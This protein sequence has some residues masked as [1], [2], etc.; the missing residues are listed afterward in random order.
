VTAAH[1][2]ALRVVGSF[3]PG[4]D[5]LA[6]K[7]KELVTEFLR[8]AESA[9]ARD[10]F[11]PG[12]VTCTGLVRHPR[13]AK[14]LFMLHHRLHRWLLPG[15]HVEESDKSLADAAGREAREETQVVIDGACAPFLAGID[16]HG[17][18]PKHDE[19]F[20]LHHDLIWCFHAATEEIAVTTEAP[21][22]MWAG[23][24]DWDRL[25]AAESIRRSI[26]RAGE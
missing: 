20:H 3:D 1:T 15:G 12:H 19:P 7:S 10:R 2:E 26:L 6:R 9:F 18:P 22:V 25:G 5:G 23:A 14:I 11:Q 4:A 24:E 21:S 8:H 16:V 17:I 13:E